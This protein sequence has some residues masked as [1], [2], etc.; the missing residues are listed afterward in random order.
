MVWTQLKSLS[1]IYMGERGAG[2][3]PEPWTAS[4]TSTA[5]VSWA[6][7]GRSWLSLGKNMCTTPGCQT[8]GV[9]SEVG[10]TAEPCGERGLF[11][12]HK[13]HGRD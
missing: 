1:L 12:G 8:R 5:R 13:E 9:S 11:I 3:G 6:D 2:R 4:S 10:E 7:Q